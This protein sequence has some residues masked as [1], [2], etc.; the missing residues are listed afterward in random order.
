MEKNLSF[1]PLCNGQVLT[2][3]SLKNFYDDFSRILLVI[4]V[5][6]VCL[7]ANAAFRLLTYIKNVDI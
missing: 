4:S 2:R 3:P 6:T 5:K 7:T 1:F